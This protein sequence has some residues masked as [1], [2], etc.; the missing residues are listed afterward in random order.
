MQMLT[1]ALTPLCDSAV[2]RSVS[3]AYATLNGA[4]FMSRVE[5][6]GYSNVFVGRV[7]TVMLVNEELQELCGN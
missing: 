1:G 6:H 2:V 3:L 5:S 4:V 7:I